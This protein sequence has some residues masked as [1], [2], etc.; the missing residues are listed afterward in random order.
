[1]TIRLLWGQFGL[2]VWFWL[3]FFWLL[4]NSPTDQ[5]AGYINFGFNTPSADM[6][7]TGSATYLG[8][9]E[10]TL[11]VNTTSFLITGKVDVTANFASGGG[12]VTT[13]FREMAATISD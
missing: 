3:L 8:Y 2:S 5:K 11:F 6:P 7:T 9:A 1:M 4:E 13:E 12:N 10:G